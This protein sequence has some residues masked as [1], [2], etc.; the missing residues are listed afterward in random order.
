MNQTVS[1]KTRFLRSQVAKNWAEAVTSI[2]VRSSAEA[3]LAQ[4][5]FEQPTDF[6]DKDAASAEALRLQGARRYM[7]I[8]LNLAEKEPDQPVKMVSDNL[9]HDI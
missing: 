2:E 6:K 8:L 5:V 3:A 7:S 4:F 9:P 1:P